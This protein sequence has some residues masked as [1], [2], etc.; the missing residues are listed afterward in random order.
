MHY[1]TNQLNHRMISKSFLEKNDD[2]QKEFVESYDECNKLVFE[3]IECD[4][5]RLVSSVDER[6]Q[7]DEFIIYELIP[8]EQHTRVEYTPSMDWETLAGFIV[9]V[10]GTICGFS[11]YGW[12][13]FKKWWKK[14][15]QIINWSNELINRCR[16]H[17]AQ[18][19]PLPSDEE[20]GAGEVGGE[21][22]ESTLDDESDESQ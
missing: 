8:K 9:T 18:V 15:W 22:E 6:R 7:G 5:H 14:E 12:N 4:E 10:F 11:F 1:K 21:E 17:G 3:E 2:K 20:R 13:P 19:G 16:R